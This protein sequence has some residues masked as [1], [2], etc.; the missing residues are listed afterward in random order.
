M[1]TLARTLNP[2]TGVESR[3]ELLWSERPN[4]RFFILS[5]SFW[6]E[7]IGNVWEAILRLK[8]QN[9]ES[10]FYLPLQEKALPFPRPKKKQRQL[11]RLPSA[12]HSF[13]STQI[14]FG[15]LNVT[16]VFIVDWQTA[17]MFIR[18]EP[19]T[20]LSTRLRQPRAVNL[21]GGSA[22]AS[23]R[24]TAIRVDRRFQNQAAQFSTIRMHCQSIET[25]WQLVTPEQNSG[26]VLD[27]WAVSASDD[28]TQCSE[29]PCLFILKAPFAS[30]WHMSVCKTLL[31]SPWR[32]FTS[33]SH[34]LNAVLLVCIPPASTK[35]RNLFSFSG[36]SLSRCP[37]QCLIFMFS[38]SP[39]WI[40]E[41]GDELWF[42]QRRTFG[43]LAFPS[44]IISSRQG[45]EEMPTYLDV[46][47]LQEKSAFITKG[48]GAITRDIQFRSH[49]PIT[50]S[51]VVQRFV[52]ALDPQLE[53]VRES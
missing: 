45:L 1:R 49:L 8:I 27:A 12:W 3:C 10:A 20:W 32:S 52:L 50:V 51:A 23:K 17:D 42:I 24:N 29:G 18:E 22:V 36:V 35:V 14:R 15:N 30:W 40:Q 25:S 19:M 37:G 39:V 31:I 28:G 6:A 38:L 53:A 26:F 41:S 7:S 21:G 9:F 43:A 13:V 48:L 2:W 34:R 47:E 44:W 4:W 5:S 46:L 33:F 11:E 16:Y